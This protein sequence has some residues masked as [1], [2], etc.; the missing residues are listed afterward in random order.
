ML[1]KSGRLQLCL[2]LFLRLCSFV[3]ASSLHKTH[4]STKGASLGFSQ[5]FSEYFSGHFFLP[6]IYMKDF[7]LLF[8]VVVFFLFSL[9]RLSPLFLLIR[10][11]CLSATLLVCCSYFRWAQIVLPLNLSPYVAAWEMVRKLVKKY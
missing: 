10:L 7:E 1:A 9:K 3:F 11:L 6:P 2:Y 5:L 4:R 8:C